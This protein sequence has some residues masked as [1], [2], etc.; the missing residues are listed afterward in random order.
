MLPPHPRNL[1]QLGG[2]TE[3]K[4]WSLAH[5]YAV[6]SVWGF[7]SGLLYI[8]ALEMPPC[9]VCGGIELKS[10]DVCFWRLNNNDTSS[11]FIAHETCFNVLVNSPR[12]WLWYFDF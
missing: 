4:M 5:A 10:D 2:P 1:F 9:D 3:F 7:L 6:T 8:R 11:G 12:T